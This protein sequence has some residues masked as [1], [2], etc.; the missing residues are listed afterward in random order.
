MSL[1]M[2]AVRATLAG[3]P[4]HSGKANGKRRNWKEVVGSQ[5]VGFEK[6]DFAEGEKFWG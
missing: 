2:T 5:G 6:D 3:L 4:V 1:R